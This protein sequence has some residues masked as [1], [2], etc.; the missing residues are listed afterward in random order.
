[1]YGDKYREFVCKHWGLKGHEIP[2]VI[3]L[4]M[5]VWPI[6]VSKACDGAITKKCIIVSLWTNVQLHLD[7][8]IW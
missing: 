1:M 5:I 4:N 3:S 8:Q 7:I 2:N 6:D